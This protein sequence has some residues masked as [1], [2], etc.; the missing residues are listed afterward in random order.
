MRVDSVLGEHHAGKLWQET[1]E[2]KADRILHEELSRLDWKS[3]ALGARR[4]KYPYKLAITTWLRVETTLSLK[5][6]AGRIRLGSSKSANATLQSWVQ[7]HGRKGRGTTS[8][9]EELGL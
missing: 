2:A 4:K 9:A 6:I 1:A 3:E 5:E 8:P 7:N